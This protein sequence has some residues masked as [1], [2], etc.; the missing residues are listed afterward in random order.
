MGLRRWGFPT[1]AL[2]HLADLVNKGVSDTLCL[3][4]FS[5]TAMHG[6]DKWEKL[7]T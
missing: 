7:R 6:K 2:E 4:G 1:P 5:P 3:L